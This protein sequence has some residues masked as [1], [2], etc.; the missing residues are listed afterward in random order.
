MNRLEEKEMRE[1]LLKLK[2]RGDERILSEEKGYRM[3][4]IKEKIGGEEVDMIF[5]HGK[6]EEKEM[7]GYSIKEKRLEEKKLLGYFPK[8]NLRRRR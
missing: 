6:L 1:Y 8:G 3:F 7:R 2:K 5:S 4:Q